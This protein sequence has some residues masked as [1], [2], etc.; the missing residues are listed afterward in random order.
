MSQYKWPYA[1]ELGQ[2]EHYDCDVLVLGVVLPAAL[3][4]LQ[5]Q[6]KANQLF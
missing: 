3:R 1:N 5:Q 2:E 6:G 4:P